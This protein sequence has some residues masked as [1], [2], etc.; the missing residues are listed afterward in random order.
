MSKNGGFDRMP[1]TFSNSSN[2]DQLVLKGLIM[3]A[4]TQQKLGQSG[5]LYGLKSAAGLHS[6]WDACS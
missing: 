5:L 6:L 1:L 3:N 2:L 4:I